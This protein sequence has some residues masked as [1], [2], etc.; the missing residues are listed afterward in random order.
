MSIKNILLVSTI[1]YIATAC[2]DA[3]IKAPSSAPVSGDEIQ[4]GAIL[5]KNAMSRTIY[6]EEIKDTNGK[7]TAIKINWLEDDRM[8]IASPQAAK[9][10][11]AASFSVKKENMGP[12]V[13]GTTD[14]HE[15]AGLLVRDDET[16]TLQWGDE[17]DH[18]F[19]SIQPD[20]TDNPISIYGAFEKDNDVVFK[21]T[22]PDEQ[23]NLVTA[24]TPTQAPIMKTADMNACFIYATKR[25]E[26][27]ASP[28]ELQYH[29]LS[30]A[31]RF[32]VNG[33]STTYGG[34]DEIHISNI[35]LHADTKIAGDFTVKLSENGEPVVEPLPTATN[36]I[37]IFNSTD[38]QANL[39]LY[40]GQSIELNAFIIPQKAEINENWYIEVQLANSMSF[41][42]YLKASSS[43]TAANKTLEMG[44]IHKLPPLP[45]IDIDKED[46]YDPS[47][48]ME[49][50]P[51]N[52]YLSEI[53]IPGSWNSL[54]WDFQTKSGAAG[55]DPFDV[56]K[57]TINEQY[58][59]GCRA[60]HLDVRWK[61]TGTSASDIN[62]LSVAVSGD[63]N[64]YDISGS[65][66]KKIMK[67]GNP[68]F[69]DMLK[70]ITSNIKKD[71]KPKN[72]YMVVFC[73]LAQN[74]YDPNNSTKN[75]MKEIS[76]ACASND[77][78]I[79][80]QNFTSSVFGTESLSINPTTMV[81]DVL[82]KVI[83]IVNCES[84]IED[85]SILPTDS[86]CLFTY[87]PLKRTSAMYQY[88]T[89]NPA[90]AN[91]YFDS[92]DI[93]IGKT[94]AGISFNNTQAQVTSDKGIDTDTGAP[95]YKSIF[96]N[97]DK[98]GYA[99]KLSE[100]ESIGNN[101]LAWSNN[102]FTRK[103]HSTNAW[104]YLG[105][106]GYKVD[107]TVFL[108]ACTDYH[109]VSGS[110]ATVASTLNNWVNDK[111]KSMSSTTGYNP[112]GLVLMNYVENDSYGTPVVHNILQLNGRFHKA[113]NKDKD[114]FPQN[115]YREF[116]SSDNRTKSQSANGWD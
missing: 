14:Q 34:V 107:Y 4:F 83:V 113:Y 67:D 86:K 98:R 73:S 51:R 6:G 76:D 71:G 96:W 84:P 56:Y 21:M 110:Y 36:D 45:Y 13:P 5:D 100:R 104:L 88:P 41:K 109:T 47:R 2:Q 3:D 46:E 101:L 75:W 11:N 60:F 62:G 27:G 18:V 17:D 29:P 103:D 7:V 39:T 114:A 40:A 19:Y 102:T 61:G 77:D 53:S 105:L 52:V 106:G 63:R 79:N 69:S 9:G 28:V 91:K 59:K 15:Y 23:F 112:V 44:M 48:W 8:F 64:T 42:K 90:V 32:T 78:V 57:N 92:N 55:S 10:R 108:G 70:A 74:S 111:I 95:D 58:N 35:I 82:G 93:Y 25:V 43:A 12:L 68:L 99:P 31:I 54:N 87:I 72:E 20:R 1:A 80:A 26:F 24:S 38:I 49:Y 116:I 37:A 89:Y 16:R 81:G 33:P 85:I 22:M 30:T 65:G 50:I 97:G 115:T 94:K 66:G